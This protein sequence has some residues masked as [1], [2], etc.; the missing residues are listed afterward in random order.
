MDV[1]FA[2]LTVTFAAV[3]VTVWLMV[4]VATVCVTVTVTFPEVPR[5]NGMVELLNDEVV[6]A[7][8]PLTAI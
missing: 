8:E 3:T 4:M 1:A 6:E 5:L 2:S 7:V